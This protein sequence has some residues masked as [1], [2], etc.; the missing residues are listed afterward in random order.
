M[1]GMRQITRQI[2][3]KPKFEKV[4]ALKNTRGR[5]ALE[6]ATLSDIVNIIVRMLLLKLS[7]NG[8][9]NLVTQGG[10]GTFTSSRG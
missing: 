1:R 8:P 2:A 10:R 5:A 4:P 7:Q 6:L 3:P 9:L